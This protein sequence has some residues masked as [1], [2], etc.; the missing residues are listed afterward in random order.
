MYFLL[1]MRIFLASYVS[2]P[3]GKSHLPLPG[4]GPNVPEEVPEV[5]QLEVEVEARFYF[6]DEWWG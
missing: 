6:G 5:D 2:L 4:H 1:K 3:E